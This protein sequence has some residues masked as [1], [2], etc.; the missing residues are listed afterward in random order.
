MPAVTCGGLSQHC[1]WLSLV[2]Q[3]KSAKAHL[4]TWQLFLALVAACD[5]TPALPQ[6]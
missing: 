5:K 6:T 3:T 4:Q 1:Q 2:R